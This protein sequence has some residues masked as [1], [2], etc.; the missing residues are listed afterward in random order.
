M[1][2]GSRSFFG[3]G[4]ITNIFSKIPKNVSTTT[5]AY[6]TIIRISLYDHYFFR[7]IGQ[8]FSFVSASVCD[9][10]NWNSRSNIASFERRLRG[11]AQTPL[12]L[13][14]PFRTST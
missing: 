14:Y 6:Y 2:L 9:S 10:R 13:P 1:E 5:L 11:E 3:E 4:V 7:G 12:F 8:E